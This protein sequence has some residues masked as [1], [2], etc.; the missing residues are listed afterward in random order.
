RSPRVRASSRSCYTRSS[1]D[2]HRLSAEDENP[3]SENLRR[4]RWPTMDNGCQNEDQ[5]SEC[6]E[7]QE[8]GS[9]MGG[10]LES[11]SCLSPTPAQRERRRMFSIMKRMVVVAPSGALALWLAVPEAPGQPYG[12]PMVGMNPRGPTPGPYSTYGGPATQT[13]NPYGPY[14]AGYDANAY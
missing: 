14:N 7:P 6:P 10:S 4:K 3:A 9:C 12:A 11:G 5:E 13:A 1:R 2:N 8:A